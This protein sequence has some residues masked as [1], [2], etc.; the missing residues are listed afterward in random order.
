MTK[1]NRWSK[2]DRNKLCLCGCGRKTKFCPHTRVKRKPRRQT[3]IV[4]IER[5]WTKFPELVAVAREASLSFEAT[6]EWW[7]KLMA[8]GFGVPKETLEE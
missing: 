2:S 7:T 6:R 1:R 4:R 8:L 5:L 3:Y